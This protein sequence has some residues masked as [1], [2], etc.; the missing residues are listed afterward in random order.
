VEALSKGTEG[1]VYGQLRLSRVSVPV[2]GLTPEAIEHRYLSWSLRRRTSVQSD[3]VMVL[4]RN[5]AFVTRAPS[6]TA[7]EKSAPS[8]SALSRSVF[9]QAW[10]KA[11]HTRLPYTLR[12]V[13]VD[14]ACN[15][16]PRPRMHDGA[17]APRRLL[18]PYVLPQICESNW[19]VLCRGAES[20]SRLKVFNPYALLALCHANALLDNLTGGPCHSHYWLGCS[21]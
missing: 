4:P 11:S 10:A 21:T 14:T 17:P 9:L 8:R 15:V 1:A 13:H 19:L 20:T 3:P 2:V 18:L 12:Y 6:R 7:L 16:L 5:C